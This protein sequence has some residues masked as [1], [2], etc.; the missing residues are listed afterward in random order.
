AGVLPVRRCCPATVELVVSGRAV[1]GGRE[2]E[3]VRVLRHA[4]AGR[5]RVGIQGAGRLAAVDVIDVEVE[6]LLLIDEQLKPVVVH[7]LGGGGAGL[8][9]ATGATVRLTDRVVEDVH[10]NRG[11]DVHGVAPAGVTLVLTVRDR[12]GG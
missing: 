10:I 7:G 12:R 3:P 5:L 8:R 9:R 4:S 1:V 11:G 2:Q 6:V